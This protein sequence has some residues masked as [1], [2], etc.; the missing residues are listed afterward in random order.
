MVRKVWVVLYFVVFVG[1]SGGERGEVE[2]SDEFVP[3]ERPGEMEAMRW[4]R[5]DLHV[6]AA[7]ASNDASPQSTPERIREVAIERG[8]DFVVLTDHSN[9][10]GSDPWTLEEDPALFNL[11][12][13]F[14]RWE[15]A[16]EL[17]DERFLMVQGNELSPRAVS[18]SVPTGHIGCIP[19]RLDGFDWDVAFVDRPRGS[20]T[21]GQALSQAQEAG[22]WAVV[23]HPYGP[24]WT[25]YDWSSFEYEG[26]EVW[27]GGA[28]FSGFDVAGIKAWA[29]DL[30][31]G[32]RVTA[33]GASDNHKVE[34]ELPGEALDPA[35]GEPSTYVWV[36]QLEWGEVVSGLR[37]GE[38]SVSDTGSPLEIDVFDGDGRWLAMAGGEVLAGGGRHVRLRGA[39]AGGGEV[40]RLE[41]LRIRRDGCEDDREEGAM[42]IPEPNWEVLGGWEVEGGGGFEEQIEVD[43]R[44]GD[45]LFSWMVPAGRPV[46]ARDV[47][48]SGAVYIK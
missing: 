36:S 44:A 46:M 1:C 28:G 40:R 10:T 14:P 25:S 3:W 19:G 30:S 35:L 17:S 48:L 32:R 43:L 33:V 5:G 45:A 2:G 9:S 8:L 18:S 22:C 23:N 6:H 39:R 13:E 4:V 12:P 11:G 41:L 37:A 38:V 20:V 47:A 42:N 26:M 21:G 16:A 24:A 29:C 15:E 27:N 31:A 34:Q 7:G